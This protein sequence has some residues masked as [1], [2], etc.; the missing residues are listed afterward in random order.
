MSTATILLTIGSQIGYRSV[1]RGISG[2]LGT[3]GP[4]FGILPFSQ[5]TLDLNGNV[6]PFTAIPNNPILYVPP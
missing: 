5:T 4:L 1:G 3:G 2:V 6:F